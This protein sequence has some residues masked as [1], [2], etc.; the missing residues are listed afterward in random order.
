[1]KKLIIKSLIILFAILVILALL[2]NRFRFI[3]FGEVEIESLIFTQETSQAYDFQW[4][5]P[6]NGYLQRLSLKFGLDEIILDQDSDLSK[7]L[8][9][10]DWTHNL[11][12][13]DGNNQPE[14]NDPLSIYRE[15]ISQN[16][17]F[18]CV[19]YAI[20]LT[21]SLN[22][23]DFPSRVLALKMKDVETIK[24]GAGHVVTETYSSE[25]DKWV[26]IDP[27]WNAIPV[28]NDIPLN[29]VEFQQA[30][31]DNR[32]EIEIPGFNNRKMVRYF[33]WI[34][35]YLYYFDTNLDNRYVNDSSPQKLM[36]VP[37]GA[38][39]PEVFQRNYPINN[40]YYTNSVTDF[41]QKPYR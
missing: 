10:T 33:N 6:D 2:A 16:R 18:R 32:N 4:S 15:A 34:G 8:A 38:K 36:L 19:E 17:N 3:P 21:G 25:F 30:L 41:Y 26:F 14:Q 29:A 22:A 1:M 27:Q 40:M 7:I 13:H 28:I 24:S 37:V 35:D 39:E 9:V 31:V 23:L 5:D 11:W 12:S 20:V